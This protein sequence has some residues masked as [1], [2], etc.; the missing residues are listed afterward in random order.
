MTATPGEPADQDDIHCSGACEEDHVDD[1]VADHEPRGTVVTG[2]HM[3][4]EGGAQRR[5]QPVANVKSDE[6][7]Q[8][9]DQCQAEQREPV[10]RFMGHSGARGCRYHDA[11]VDHPGQQ[12]PAAQVR[13]PRGDLPYR[14]RWRQDRVHSEPPGSY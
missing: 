13:K 10:S 8:A 4:P 7:R 9:A 2:G 12:R 3:R 1:P 14:L 6:G 11:L 5:Q